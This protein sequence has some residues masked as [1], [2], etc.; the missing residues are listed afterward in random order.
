MSTRLVRRTASLRVDL[1]PCYVQRVEEGIA[2]HLNQRLLRWGHDIQGILLAYDQLHVKR[3][4]GRIHPFHA[5]VRV[6]AMARMLVFQPQPGCRV[7]GTVTR[8]GRAAINLTVLGAFHAT[9]TAAEV[10]QHFRHDPQTRAYV[11]D[12]RPE[13]NLVVG[14]EVE[15]VVTNLQVRQGK[16]SLE[17]SLSK[18]H[19]ERKRKEEAKADASDGNDAV[20]RVKA[21]PR[22]V[23]HEDPSAHQAEN[24]KGEDTRQSKE[25][26][27]AKSSR[28][29][30]K[31]D[32][33]SAVTKSSPKGESKHKKRRRR[34][35]HD[36]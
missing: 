3:R 8:V 31:T 32:D 22:G 13:N 30:S 20:T 7:R 34:E 28:K 17:G 2:A 10:G 26:N 11:H 14:K 27:K 21:E 36:E 24:D 23:I 9:I 35:A 19:H 25:K 18:H 5:Y 4:P 15:F 16:C 1:P 12:S 33:E 6:H 29:R